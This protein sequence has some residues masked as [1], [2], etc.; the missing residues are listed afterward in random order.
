MTPI[1]RI[2]QQLEPIMDD[3]ITT[4]RYHPTLYDR[5]MT[6]SEVES[7]QHSGIQQ[8]DY[9][10]SASHVDYLEQVAYEPLDSQ[11]ILKSSTIL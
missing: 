11:D 9:Q 6:A 5:W 8:G 1:Q 2:S 10:Q 3:P 4:M 7:M